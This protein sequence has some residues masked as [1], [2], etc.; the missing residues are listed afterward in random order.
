MNSIKNNAMI[1]LGS[2]ILATVF[3]LSA[4]A[5]SERNEAAVKDRTAP[6]AKVC[7]QGDDSCGAPVVAAATGPKSAEDIYNGS[8][9]A[10]HSTGA[11][12]APKLG[13][14][15]AWSP[16]LAKGMDVLYSNGINGINGMPPKGLCM[17]CSDDEIK[18]TVEYMAE[19]SK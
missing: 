9:A 15:A 12:G 3:S 17:S 11:A 8:C 18:A 7:L 14:I 10:C 19:N 4:L 2:L 6:V 5:I 1:K 13:D 16:R